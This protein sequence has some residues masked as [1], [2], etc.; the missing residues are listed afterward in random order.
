MK[1]ISA[2]LKKIQNKGN[3]ITQFIKF[4]IV[5]VFNTSITLS[6]IFILSFVF[7]FD[8]RISNAAGYLAGFINSFI[9]NKFWTFR[10]Q[11]K[12]NV[13]FIKFTLTFL[14]CYILQF[15]FLYF[16]Y[17]ILKWNEPISQ[18]GSNIIYTIANF[19][20]NK[21]LTFN[22]GSKKKEN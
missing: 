10:S 2:G 1:L 11:G 13:E 17:Q 16:F 7:N 12:W 6:I 22:N 20:I 21:F 8:Y 15:L 5:G 18:I 19:T 3:F 4:I 14:F 9:W